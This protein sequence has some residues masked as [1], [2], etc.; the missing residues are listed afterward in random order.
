MHGG[1]LKANSSE[2]VRR[3]NSSA[4]LATF[5]ILLVLWFVLSGHFDLFHVSFGIICCGLVAFLS[6]DLLFHDLHWSLG[7]GPFLRFM[8]YLPWLFYQI[9]LANLHVAKMV[10][11]P[12]MP[13]A[14]RIIEFR[15]KLKKDLA[16]TTLGN[17]ITLTPGTITV[18][19]R[20]D[21][22]LVHALT[23]KVTDDLM[24]GAMENRVAAIFREASSLGK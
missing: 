4:F 23:Q 11:H 14:P 18:D 2:S 1:A 24:S 21:T 16:I 13:I 6:H 22:F 5:G 20:E 3:F 15:T 10:L 19:I 8:G 7:G 12:K 17:S 9:V